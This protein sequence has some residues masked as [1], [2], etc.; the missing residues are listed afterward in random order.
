MTNLQLSNET[1][2]DHFNPTSI[3][4][5]ISQGS[6]IEAVHTP[7]KGLDVYLD[8]EVIETARELHLI[9]TTHS[10]GEVKIRCHEKHGDVDDWHDIMVP[11]ISV[12]L[13]ILR[14]SDAK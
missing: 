2:L 10:G 12:N 5:L 7:E 14:S 3:S 13:E 4:E 1:L 6:K 11:N 8:D 9:L